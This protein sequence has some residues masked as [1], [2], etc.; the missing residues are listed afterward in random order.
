[1]ED[2]ERQLRQ[3]LSRKEQPAS[4]EA[5]VFAAIAADRSARRTSWRWEAL[6]ASVLL[7]AG[8]WAQH[9]HAAGEAAKARLRLA[10]QGHGHGTIENSKY[11]ADID[12]GRMIKI[13]LLTC[14]ALAPLGAQ[15]LK[16][17]ASLDRLAA[18]A[19]EVVDVTMD[20]NLLQLAGRF[21][22]D[23]NAD[24]AQVKKAHRRPER[25]LRQELRISEG[26]GNIRTPTS[27]R[28]ARSFIL[29]PGRGLSACVA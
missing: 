29:R 9:E 3:A 20:A 24:D 5:H 25:D 27:N 10:L 7:V 18:K 21:L 15:E 28:S 11:G 19:T 23:K 6:A 1:M 2:F 12:G 14:I 16:L 8:L 13:A 17:P 4:F 26:R 22:S